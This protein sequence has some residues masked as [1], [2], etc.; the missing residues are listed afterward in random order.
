MASSSHVYPGPPAVCQLSGHSNLSVG[1]GA[2]FQ[3]QVDDLGLALHRRH[4]ERDATVL[5][6]AVYWR[7]SPDQCGPCSA[8]EA[9]MALMS[10]STTPPIMPGA[11]SYDTDA[12]ATE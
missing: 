11:H 5:A 6:E 1:I 8:W 3:Q 7:S 9:R 4:V 10:E 2:S 12:A